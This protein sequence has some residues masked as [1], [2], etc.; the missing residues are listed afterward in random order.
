MLCCRQLP[1]M[2]INAAFLLLLNVTSSGVTLQ[3]QS[4]PTHAIRCGLLTL[5]P[6]CLHIWSVW[7]IVV[8][9]SQFKG[10]YIFT[11]KQ[12]RTRYSPF[13]VEV[14]E[15]TNV[16]SNVNGW[17]SVQDGGTW[18]SDTDNQLY[19][20]ISCRIADVFLSCFPRLY[21]GLG[22]LYSCVALLDL[23]GVRV[24]CLQF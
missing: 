19:L 21:P 18:R 1:H 11:Q 4:S 9:W 12:L 14:I 2:F 3:P 7:H 17:L 6:R 13:P 5:G 10:H 23:G 22:P 15:L 20:N 8:T 16:T 24:L